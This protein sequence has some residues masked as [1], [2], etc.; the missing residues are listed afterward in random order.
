MF[1]PRILEIKTALAANLGSRYRYNDYQPT[2]NDLVVF[3]LILQRGT[4]GPPDMMSASEGGSR[5]KEKRTL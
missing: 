5:I 2:L 1:Y 4:R 3:F